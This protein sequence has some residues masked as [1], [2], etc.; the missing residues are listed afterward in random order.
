MDNIE[1]LKEKYS[2]LFFRNDKTTLR[3]GCFECESG[4]YN[5]IDSLCESIVNECEYYNNRKQA[6]WYPLVLSTYNKINSY[7]YKFQIENKD[8]RINK[9]PMYYQPKYIAYLSKL[10]SKLLNKLYKLSRKK[11]ENKEIVYPYFVCIKEK[12]GEMRV[13]L[14]WESGKKVDKELIYKISGMIDLAEKISIRTC[15]NTGDAGSVYNR[16]H[17]YKTLSPK[18]AERLGY[19][20]K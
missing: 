19:V 15:E 1:I 17:W 3:L 8:Y 5:I 7:L 12:F 20:K 14:E 16:N 13:W 18:E 2:E 4:W 9:L 6:F 11:Y 10:L